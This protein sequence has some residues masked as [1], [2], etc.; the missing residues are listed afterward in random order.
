MASWPKKPL[1][2]PGMMASGAAQSTKALPIPSRVDCSEKA[3]SA[4]KAS[5]STSEGAAEVTGGA[6]TEVMENEGG[7]ER[8]PRDLPNT[9]AASRHG[10]SGVRVHTVR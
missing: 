9:A 8:G 6:P 7:S 5:A 4:A 10:P 3:E 1:G 2:P